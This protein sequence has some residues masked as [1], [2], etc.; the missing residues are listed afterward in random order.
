MVT[1]PTTTTT[2]TTTD[3]VTI[4]RELPLFHEMLNNLCTHVSESTTGIGNLCK[5]IADEDANGRHLGLSFLEMKCHLFLEYLINI[6][7]S[8][9]LKLDG[10]TI[11]GA[12]CIDHLVEVRTVLTKIKPMEKKLKYQ[13]DK[14]I[15]SSTPQTNADDKQHALNYKPNL[16]NLIAKDD[17]D[18]EDGASDDN[19]DGDGGRKSGVYVPPKLTAVPYEGDKLSREERR[20]EKARKKALNSNLIADMREELG[21]QPEE[22]SDTRKQS[23][24]RKLKDREDEREKY[25]E[26]NLTRLT[27]TKKDKLMKRKLGM[28]DEVLKVGRFGGMGD[29][30]DSDDD[31]PELQPKSKKSKGK[32]FAS[33]KG[34]FKKRMQRKRK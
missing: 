16:D 18:G 15:K 25:E 5:M 12:P 6:T 26:D 8:M 29:D 1:N 9:L 10:R 28:L 13:I 3:D 19:E 23:T 21:D 4:A 31:E 2:T 34:K 22:I 30:D 11:E 14:L 20:L 7:Q 27:L 32:K 17:D 24:K 33:G